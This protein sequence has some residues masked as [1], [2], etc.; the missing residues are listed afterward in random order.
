MTGCPEHGNL[1]AYTGHEDDRCP[2]CHSRWQ[3]IIGRG[4]HSCEDPN[5]WHS[6]TRAERVRQAAENRGRATKG[7][8]LAPKAK[9]Q[10]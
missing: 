10:P 4:Y 8:W 7:P 9:G 2:W 6:E 5:A 1:C 3:V